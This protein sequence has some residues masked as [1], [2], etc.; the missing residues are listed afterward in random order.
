MIIPHEQKQLLVALHFLEVGP[1]HPHV[2]RENHVHVQVDGALD[3]PKNL[4]KEEFGEPGLARVVADVDAKTVSLTSAGDRSRMRYR[5]QAG[6]GGQ[7]RKVLN[8][9]E[10]KCMGVWE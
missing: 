1:Q 2:L 3:V 9:T 10:S 7:S 4:G 5:L 8:G 6:T